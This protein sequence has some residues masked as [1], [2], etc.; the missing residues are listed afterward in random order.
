M[1]TFQNEVIEADMT[2]KDEVWQIFFNGAS[3]MGPKGKIVAG[4]GVVFVSQ[5]NHVLPRAFSLTE[6]CFNN[7]AEYNAMLI[8]LQF[9]Q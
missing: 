4:V 1:K 3:K 6:P 7:V 8:D 9:A 5:H 2:S